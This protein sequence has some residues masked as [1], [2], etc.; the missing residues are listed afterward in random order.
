M[1]VHISLEYKANWQLYEFPVAAVTSYHK[2]RG[3]KQHRFILLP[4]RRSES[5]SD[6]TGQTAGAG[7]A[8]FLLELQE[9]VW[10]CGFLLSQA[11]APGCHSRKMPPS[12]C[13]CV[14]P[15]QVIQGNGPSQDPPVNTSAESL[16]PCE[17]THT[18]TLDI[19]TWPC[20]EGRYSVYP[21]SLVGK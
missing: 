14:G 8:V 19:R 17:G 6:V 20:G 15:T 16:L 9:I 10:P 18:Q 13:G 11:P 21:S 3:L 12:P 5:K 1:L 4:F 2:L 7:R